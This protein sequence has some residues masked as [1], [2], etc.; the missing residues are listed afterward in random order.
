MSNASG[1]AVHLIGRIVVML[2]CAVVVIRCRAADSLTLTNG[3]KITCE[4]EKLEK[5]KLTV[6]IPY[7]DDTQLVF[8]WKMVAS[9]KSEANMR[10]RLDDGTERTAKL[11]PAKEPGY[12]ALQGSS[13]PLA[14]NRIASL[15]TEE[16]ESSWTDNLSFDT[17]LSWGYTG[18]ND[19]YTIF[20]TTQSFYWG[21][22]WEG[23]L[24]GTW[25][26]NRS[27][28]QP[29]LN[30]PQGELNVNRYLV[31][32][33]FIFPWASGIHASQGN[34]GRG[35]IWQLGGGGGWSFIKKKDNH[36]EIMGGMVAL[37]DQATVFITQA[38]GQQRSRSVDERSPAFLMAG[39]WQ[40]TSEGITWM[41][42]VLYNHP[43]T[44]NMRSQLGLQSTFD[45]PIV[46]PLSVDVNV[47][48]YTSPLSSSLFSVKGLSIST[49]FGVHF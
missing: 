16:N 18:T 39:R 28:G 22:R 23:A 40:K 31:K 19:L 26:V 36:L 27:G 46:G 2:I 29:T 35:S 9:V 6:T 33:F 38:N 10:L 24:L 14:L 21:D 47:Q 45:I 41:I 13:A 34:N 8:D 15:E 17:D 1:P 48:D 49:G 30:Q 44:A 32:R 43:T 25:N 12:L 5:G 20:L 3:D 4:I 11:E 37:T 7:A 42:Q